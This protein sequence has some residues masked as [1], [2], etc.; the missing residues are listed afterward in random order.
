MKKILFEIDESTGEAK[1]CNL[2][3]YVLYPVSALDAKK[4]QD[5][6]YQRKMHAKMASRPVDRFVWADYKIG[7]L[8]QPDI[9]CADVSRMVFL[10]TYLSYHGNLAGDN[11]R[12]L[13][14][15]HVKALLGLSE[16]KFY[17]FWNFMM[18]SQIFYAAL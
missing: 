1:Q 5:Y 17:E 16:S 14:K 9:P 18:E 11:H 8:W 3:E 6:A 15:K 4:A 13:K 10:A 2:D 7:G 12:A